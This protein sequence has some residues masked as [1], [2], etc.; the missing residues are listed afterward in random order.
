[1]S[2]GTRATPEQIAVANWRYDYTQARARSRR[3]VCPDCMKPDTS[4]E[5]I[6]ELR[7]EEAQGARRRPR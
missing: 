6:A 5:H 4:C 7:H 1:M 2:R 3:P